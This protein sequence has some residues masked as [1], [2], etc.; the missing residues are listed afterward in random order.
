M[1]DLNDALLL[2]K[3]DL[4][5]IGMSADNAAKMKE[6]N[7]LLLQTGVSTNGQQTS[8]DAGYI[9]KQYDVQGTEAYKNRLANDIHRF[10]RI[11]N[12]EDDRF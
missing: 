3:G 8:A 6:A 11:P 10:S 5:A 12:L 1:S 7:T 2:I 9:Y 4:E